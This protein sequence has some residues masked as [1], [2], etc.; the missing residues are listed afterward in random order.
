MN[1]PVSEKADPQLQ[2]FNVQQGVDILFRNGIPRLHGML[3]VN[4][5]N[6][7]ANGAG[8]FS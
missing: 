2:T 8:P 7:F 5:L 1:I 4:L 3:N 6:M